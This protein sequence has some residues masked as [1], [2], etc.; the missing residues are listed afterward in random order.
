MN[1]RHY[2]V[3]LQQAAEESP[4]FARL[5]QLARESGERFKAIE[6]SIPAALRPC[7]RPGAIEGG[8]WCLLVDNSAVAAKLRQLLPVLQGKLSHHGWE[9]SLIRLKVGS[10]EK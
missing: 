4:T 9:V 2:P 1:R 7:I 6:S 3:P 5:A 8:T 10:H